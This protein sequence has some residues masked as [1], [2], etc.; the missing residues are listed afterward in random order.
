MK[1][2]VRSLDYF[3]SQLFW[4][5]QFPCL[6]EVVRSY[7]RHPLEDGVDLLRIIESTAKWDLFQSVVQK[8]KAHNYPSGL[9]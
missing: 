1:Y 5:Q 7:S 2:C 3:A 6:T 4:L 9:S 8:L